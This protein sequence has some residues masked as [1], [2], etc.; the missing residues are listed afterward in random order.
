MSTDVNAAGA[1]TSVLVA[2]DHR[3]S[4]LIAMALEAEPDFTCAGTAATVA[5]ALTMVDELRPDLVLMDVQLGDGD[6]I[7]ATAELTRIYPELR[8]V[9]L[10]AHGDT[11]LMQRA[12][13]ANACCVLPGDGS[14]PDL[15]DKMRS[16]LRG[17]LLVHPAT[18][19]D[20]LMLNARAGGLGP[21]R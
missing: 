5:E 8:V 6:G 4:D 3:T 15:L 14:L 12:A 2:D 1:T 16:L 17:G 19:K 11:A 7:A 21:H 18:V 20:Q 13:D 10:A 9:V